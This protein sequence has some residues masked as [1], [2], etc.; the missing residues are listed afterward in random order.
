MSLN[1]DGPTAKAIDREMKKTGQTQTD[2]VLWCVRWVLG[3]AK[4]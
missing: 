2:V 1:I 4:K 3:G